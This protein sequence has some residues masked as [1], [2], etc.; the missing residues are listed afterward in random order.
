MSPLNENVYL[1]GEDKVVLIVDNNS[2]VRENISVVLKIHGYKCLEARTS[3]EAKIMYNEF[4]IDLVLTDINMPEKD[5]LDL[6]EEL[7]SMDKKAKIIA[8]SCGGEA[9]STACLEKVLGLGAANYCVE[10]F[11]HRNFVNIVDSTIQRPVH[12]YHN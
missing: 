7:K 5:G 8:I 11:N 4:P 2:E 1:Q 6:I 10:P 9:Y 12:R 3:S